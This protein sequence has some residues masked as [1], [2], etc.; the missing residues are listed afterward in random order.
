MKSEIHK[1]EIRLSHL[2]KVQEK[3]IMDMEFCITRRDII[4]N[5]A[6]AKEKRNPRGMHNQRFI[7]RKRLDDQKTKIKQIAKVKL[8]RPGR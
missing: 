8:T 6:I 2:K 3:L 1:M 5:G 4:L 7:L